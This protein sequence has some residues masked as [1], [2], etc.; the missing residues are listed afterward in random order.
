MNDEHED[1][2]DDHPEDGFEVE[3]DEEPYD[4]TGA[5]DWPE[6]PDAGWQAG[7]TGA[8]VAAGLA[9]AVTALLLVL[10]WTAF[11]GD[12]DDARDAADDAPRAARAS[13]ASTPTPLAGTEQGRRSRLARCVRAQE[14]LQETLA[15][16]RP[17]LDQWQVHVGAMNKLVVGEITLRQATEFWE[18]TRVGAQ[19]RVGEFDESLAVLRTEGVDCPGPALLARGARALPACAREVQAAVRALQAARVSVATWEEHIRHMDMLRLGQMT[20][21]QATE[22]WLASWRRGVK[23]L[24]DYE[25]ASG[26]A[27][28]L[29]ER[30]DGCA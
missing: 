17:A 25:A 4:E 20:P 11:G 13:V 10:V 28:E 9:G 14:G 5:D 3:P 23:D 24:D 22:M 21:Q 18:R 12:E 19:R 29:A 1:Q 30:Q 7:G 27:R 26:T 6:S 16:A 2:H 15:T 8:L